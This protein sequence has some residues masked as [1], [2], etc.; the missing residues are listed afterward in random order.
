MAENN[1]GKFA[2]GSGKLAMSMKPGVKI[3]FV[4][5]LSSQPSAH[6]PDPIKQILSLNSH[7]NFKK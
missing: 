6:C 4:P 3:Y 2:E 1:K 7:E 5:L